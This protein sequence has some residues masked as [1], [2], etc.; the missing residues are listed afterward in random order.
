MKRF[1][2]LGISAP[3]L[4]SF[5]WS[6]WWC[7]S[8]SH[9]PPHRTL[10]TLWYK[11]TPFQILNYGCYVVK[12]SISYLCPWPSINTR[13]LQKTWHMVMQRLV[14]F[15]GQMTMSWFWMHLVYHWSTEHAPLRRLISGAWHSIKSYPH[16]SVHMNASGIVEI[17]SSWPSRGQKLILNT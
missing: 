4:T 7:D 6:L 5:A 17:K 10:L 3:H 15:N 14:I 13:L 16:T 8:R 12:F 9:P 1:P 11:H 2:C